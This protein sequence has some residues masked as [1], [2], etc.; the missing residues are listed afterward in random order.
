MAC[1]GLLIFL[2]ILLFIYGGGDFLWLA[3]LTALGALLLLVGMK[4]K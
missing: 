1:G 2:A 3:V 4:V